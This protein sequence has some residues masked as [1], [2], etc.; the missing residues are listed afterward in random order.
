M[1]AASLTEHGRAVRIDAE[2]GTDETRS[3]S[4]AR[5]A[6]HVWVQQASTPISGRIG[7]Q[8]LDA[9]CRRERGR[10]GANADFA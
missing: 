5:R 10:N 2:G 3:L 6:L 9:S 8:L 1:A 4:L 7:E